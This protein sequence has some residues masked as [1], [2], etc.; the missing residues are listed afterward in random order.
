MAL[1]V[2]CQHMRR[3]GGFPRAQESMF[4][5]ISLCGTQG[6]SA[7]LAPSRSLQ[8]L[9]TNAVV[10]GEEFLLFAGKTIFKNK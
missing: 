7:R 6:G 4:L 5:V 3:S 2:E 8:S 10:S 1:A 9:S